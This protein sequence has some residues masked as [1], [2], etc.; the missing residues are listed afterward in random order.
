MEESSGQDNALKVMVGSGHR[1]KKGK[2]EK[3]D[4][5]SNPKGVRS[6]ENGMKVVKN[7]D[8]EN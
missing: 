4:V 2:V 1:A 6:G 3:S 7:G 8:D 5:D